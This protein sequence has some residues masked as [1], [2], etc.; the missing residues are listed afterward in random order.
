MNTKIARRLN[1]A[2][3]KSELKKTGEEIV[4]AH[5]VAVANGFM[6]MPI[7]DCKGA[8]STVDG[9]VTVAVAPRCGIMSIDDLWALKMAWGADRL[10]VCD[11]VG[12]TVLLTYKR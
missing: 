5:N 10:E 12:M 2:V 11:E 1:E 4:M 9:V 6:E 3:R 8:T 7:L